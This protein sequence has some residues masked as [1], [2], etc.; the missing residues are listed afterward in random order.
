M[1][2]LHVAQVLILLVIGAGCL[3]ALGG[4]AWEASR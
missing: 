3:V 4:M 2:A 1:T